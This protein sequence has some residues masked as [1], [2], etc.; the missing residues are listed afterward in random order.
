MHVLIAYDISDNRLRGKIFAFLKEKG[1]HVQRSV[2]E[3]ELGPQSLQEVSRFMRQMELGAED[4]V[5]FYPLCR[6]CVRKSR[7]L[8]QGLESA[9]DDWEII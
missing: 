1:M 9:C 6:H 3:C 5:L 7:L 8:G 2:F 4:S